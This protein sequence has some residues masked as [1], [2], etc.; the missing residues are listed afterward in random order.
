M[1]CGALPFLLII[2]TR[3]ELKTFREKVD[4]LDP[5]RYG[6]KNDFLTRIDGL[7]T[8]SFEVNAMDSTYVDFSMEV[9]NL[10]KDIHEKLKLF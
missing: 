4:N 10:F 5:E 9:Q 3:G 1:S 7:I 8:K 6:S 2:M